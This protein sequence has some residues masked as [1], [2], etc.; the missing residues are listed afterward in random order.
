MVQFDDK[1]PIM[2]IKW[3]I[4]IQDKYNDQLKTKHLPTQVKVLTNYPTN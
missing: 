4:L 3:L 2:C 1:V